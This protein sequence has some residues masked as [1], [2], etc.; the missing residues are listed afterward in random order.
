MRYIAL[1]RGINVGKKN[2][3]SMKLL[4]SMFEDA[5]YGNV[6]TYI[7]SGNVL[8]DSAEDPPK[9]QRNLA[10]MI[11]GLVED[12]IP[13]IVITQSG[14][15]G[16]NRA[17]PETWQ[18]DAVQS[19]NVGFLLP[20]IDKEDILVELPF[21][22]EYVQVLYVKGALI[23]NVKRENLNKSRVTN[24]AGHAYYKKMTIRNVNTLRKL[25]DM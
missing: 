23:W 4:K 18:N 1:I 22:M 11:S 24:L 13:V 9:I 20:E 7:N 14:L 8:F 17:V 10:R 5:G 19:T 21:K 15:A 25:A 16:I 3:I 12:E 6:V 2:W